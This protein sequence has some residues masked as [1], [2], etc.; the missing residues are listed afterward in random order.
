[1]K[2]SREK[3]H[4]RFGGHCSYCGISLDLK[5]MQIDHFNPIFRGWDNK[6]LEGFGLERGEEK[7]ENLFPSCARCNR[8]KSTWNIEQFRREIGLQIERLN[9]R[10]NNYRMA[11]DFGLIKE[12]EKE[13]VFFFETYN[14]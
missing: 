14:K 10:S 13:V 4:Q 2:I 8:W 7:E 12:T 1:M 5:K 6:V 9:K 11:K 3:I